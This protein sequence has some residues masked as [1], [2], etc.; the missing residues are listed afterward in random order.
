MVF[1]Q[2]IAAPGPVCP[3]AISI[4]ALAPVSNMWVLSERRIPVNPKSK[5]PGPGP[6][7][8]RETRNMDLYSN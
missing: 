8:V 4:S 5:A 3:Q 1:E 7:G 2:L 6:V